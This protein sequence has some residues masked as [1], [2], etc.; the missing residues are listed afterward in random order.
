VTGIRAVVRRAYVGDV[1]VVGGGFAGLLAARA[2]ERSGVATTLVERS[3]LAGAQSGHSH[4]YIHR[5][6]AYLRSGDAIA[7]AL[8]PAALRWE[9]TLGRFGIPF[10]ATQSVIGFDSLAQRSAAARRW[11]THRLGGYVPLSGAE[12]AAETGGVLDAGV[13][14][15]CPEKVADFST[16]ARHVVEELSACRMVAGAVE[17]IVPGAGDEVAGVVVRRPGGDRVELVATCYVLA[18]GTGLVDLVSRTRARA[19]PLARRVSYMLV[20]RHR[21]LPAVAS[22]YPGDAHHGLFIGVRG[23]S[24]DDGK[25]TWLISNHSSFDES[26][27]PASARLGLRQLARSVAQVTT[28]L[29]LDG[30]VWSWY[31]A[32]K[33]ELW[34]TVGR[35]VGRWGYAGVPLPHLDTGVW[36]NAAV[37]VPV[38]LTLALGLADEVARWVTSRRAPTPASGRLDRRR[39]HPGG[40]RDVAV[41]F[42]D[43]ARRTRRAVRRRKRASARAAAQSTAARTASATRCC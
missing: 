19:G 39:S 1:L 9:A 7:R 14:A 34:G 28:A 12:V 36:R 35:A 26:G 22:V 37:A 27:S 40:G 5:G 32:P 8:L 2:L 18:G 15:A 25:V 11:T 24:G 10:E 41:V 33:L 38:K 30:L 4:G 6:Y 42:L 20:L 29:D 13:F 23:P 21:S 31:A 43:G 17:R 3:S 16:V